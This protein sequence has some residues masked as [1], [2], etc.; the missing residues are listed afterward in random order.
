V[1]KEGRRGSR[2]PVEH[3][4]QQIGQRGFAERA[5]TEAREGDAYLHAGN[6]AIKPAKEFLRWIHSKPVF[7]EWFT[8]QQGYTDGATKDWEKDPV[9]NVDPILLPFRD[10]PSIGIAA[11]NE[12]LFALMLT[13][14]RAST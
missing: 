11:W 3:R 14:S 9:W 7:E 5:E 2:Q 6:D 1:N 10:L 4:P 13:F 8:S 12:Y